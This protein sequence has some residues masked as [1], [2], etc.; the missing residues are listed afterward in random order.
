MHPTSDKPSNH[1]VT[2]K[3]AAELLGVSEHAI[4]Q[5]IRRN[6]L[7]SDKDADGRVYVLLDVDNELSGETSGK[8]SDEQSD[9]NPVQMLREQ[10]QILRE[11]LDEA[12]AANRENR[13]IIAALT[14]RIPAIE[15]AP[16]PRESPVSA[17]N[18]AGNG[19]PPENQGRVPER[20]W[21]RRFFG[22]D[23]PRGG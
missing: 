22:F 16:E 8:A 15:E 10:N 14:Q 11:Q 21:W 9:V 13:R 2:V 5:R 7:E 20:S 4:R 1:R 19:S 12:H 17:S 3:E 18:D 6:T 23:E